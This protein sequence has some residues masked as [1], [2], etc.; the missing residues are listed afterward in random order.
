MK[1]DDIIRKLSSRKLWMA[2]LLFV[3]G[4]FF[5]AGGDATELDKIL[6]AACKIAGMASFILGEAFADAAGAKAKEEAS[7][8]VTE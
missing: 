2:L 5:T 4:G 1:F 8:E 7:D 6:D 3:A